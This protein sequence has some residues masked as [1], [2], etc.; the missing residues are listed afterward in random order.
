MFTLIIHILLALIALACFAFDVWCM[1]KEPYKSLLKN[2]GPSRQSVA[3]STFSC[4]NN[5]EILVVIFLMI[6][7]LVYQVGNPLV[8]WL[9]VACFVLAIPLG[10]IDSINE[11]RNRKSPINPRIM[12][13]VQHLYL[14]FL[15]YLALCLIGVKLF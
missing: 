2:A 9:A 12:N 1:I 13:I 11:M 4:L 6:Y 5:A 15:P 7:A 10:I 8:A 3:L 14:L